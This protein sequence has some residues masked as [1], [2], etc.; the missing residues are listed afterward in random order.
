MPEVSVNRSPKFEKL[1]N[2]PPGTDLI[3][4]I[5]G[6]GGMKTYEAS[7]AVAVHATINEKRCV[8]LRDEKE[9]IRESIL[10]EVLLR[11]DTANSNGVLDRYFDRL[12]T[13]I[14]HK[15]TGEM[16]VF[17]K[18]FRASSND[19]KANLKSVSNVDIAVVE[20]AEDIR[21]E[22]KFNTFQDSIRNEGAVVIVILNT[23]D[24]GHWIVKRYFTT[25]PVKPKDVAPYK[26]TEKE[27]DG[28]FKIVPK[29]IPGVVVIQTNYKDNE[30]LP[31]KTV[32]RYEAYGNKE[33]ARYNL[34]HYLTA[35]LG[36][37]TTGKTGQVFKKVKPIT[38]EDYL[39]LP[40]REYY[41]QDFGTASPAGLVGVKIHRN[42]IWFREMNYK[43]MEVKEIGKLYS[44]LGFNFGDPIIADHADKEACDKLEAGWKYSELDPDEVE[45]YPRLLTGYKIIRCQK[46]RG[47][48]RFRIN[49]LNEM[50]M[51]CT[52][53]S[54]NAW[55]EIANYVYDVDKNKMPTDD[56]VDLF[57]HLLDPLGYVAVEVKM[58]KASPPESV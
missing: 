28:Y 46:G 45:K 40:Y 31:T 2:V 39:A 47:A 14:K 20:E 15:K 58:P 50:N 33:D 35:I 57:N 36:F 3:V 43:P 13:G 55:H 38:L 32:Q 16:M 11:Y 9:L 44:T 8:I 49:M 5:G 52:E 42:S 6:R 34:H 1:Y 53:D 48:V 10:N 23:P 37:A 4:L 18:G 17:T 26:I 29:K 30:H 21:D 27:L 19:K 51:Y 56:P 12:D 54:K 24:V 25:V 22:M 41:G 7:K